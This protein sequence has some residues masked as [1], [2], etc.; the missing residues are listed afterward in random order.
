MNKYLIKL[1]D[2]LDKKGLHK[3]TDYVDWIMKESADLEKE[4]IN[5]S[6]FTG[7]LSAVDF[8]RPKIPID[9]KEP[10]DIAIDNSRKPM[11]LRKY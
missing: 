6:E 8:P 4:K 3:E 9:I 7:R 11:K 2:H 10:K 1:A 5:K